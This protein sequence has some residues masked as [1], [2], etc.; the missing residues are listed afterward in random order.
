MN[1]TVTIGEDEVE[2]L[3]LNRYACRMAGIMGDDPSGIAD[4][5]WYKHDGWNHG[6]HAITW[7]DRAEELEMVDL[8]DLR[9]E[10]EFLADQGLTLSVDRGAEGFDDRYYVYKNDWSNPM[11]EGISAEDAIIAA[12]KKTGWKLGNAQKV[13]KEKNLAAQKVGYQSVTEAT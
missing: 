8:L 9:I 12:I 5:V 2:R 6:G 4:L 1:K 3:R 11:G 13:L 7:R 10:M